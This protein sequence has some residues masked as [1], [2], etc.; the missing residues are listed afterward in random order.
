MRADIFIFHR[1]DQRVLRCWNKALG[2][3]ALCDDA[4][5]RRAR[6]CR[7]YALCCMPGHFVSLPD[8][9]Q[10]F[11][12]ALAALAQEDGPSAEAAMARLAKSEDAQAFVAW[13]VSLPGAE[14][15]EASPSARLLLSPGG[16]GHAGTRLREDV[17]RTFHHLRAHNLRS[18]IAQ[19]LREAGRG[20]A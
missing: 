17:A 1:F 11:F 19:A 20:I 3:W 10:G 18:A 12:N 15:D 6:A 2:A 5:C 8:G 13:R 4:A 16:G 14:R 9:V 7:G